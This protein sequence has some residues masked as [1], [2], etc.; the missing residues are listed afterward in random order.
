VEKFGA[1][2]LERMTTEVFRNRQRTSARNGILKSEAVFHFANVLRNHGLNYLQDVSPRVSDSA[3]D[4]ELCKVRGQSSGIST[5]YFFMLAGTE[6]LIKPDR[7][8]GRFLKRC[9]NAEPNPH[10]AHFLISS[11]CEM[12]LTRYPDLT[13]RLLDNVIWNYERATSR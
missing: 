9:L 11:A 6:N 7:W 1:M 10:E 8:I 5:R 2:G 3:L 4:D 12:L 13:P